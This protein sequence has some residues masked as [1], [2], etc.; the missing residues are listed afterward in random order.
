MAEMCMYICQNMMFY[1]EK[2]SVNITPE[3]A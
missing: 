3:L 1:L 2:I